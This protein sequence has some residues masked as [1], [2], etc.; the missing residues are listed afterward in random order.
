MRYS[1]AHKLRPARHSHLVSSLRCSTAERTPAAISDRPAGFRACSA[2]YTTPLAPSRS[3]ATRRAACT[4]PQL[5][6]PPCRQARRRSLP[7]SDRAAAAPETRPSTSSTHLAAMRAAAI[8][9]AAAALLLLLP[10]LLA[11]SVCCGDGFGDWKTARATYYGALR[12]LAPPQRATACVVGRTRT[13]A[14]WPGR[15]AR[16]AGQPPCTPATPAA[17]QA[18]TTGPST[19]APAATATY[20]ETSRT[21]GMWCVG[22][23]AGVLLLLLML[24]L[25][26][27]ATRC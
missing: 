18:R 5:K 7:A 21:A 26:L 8:R 2:S 6:P 24:L 12:Q 16:C 1:R 3:P 20:G 9:P 23:R 10:S 11:V 17:R 25:L 13:A 22:L 4:P 15:C 19:R 14:G 27:Q